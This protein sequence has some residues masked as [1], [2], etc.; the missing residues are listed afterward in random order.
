MLCFAFAIALLAGYTIGCAL[1]W[2]RELNGFPLLFTCYQPWDLWLPIVYLCLLLGR[3]SDGGQGAVI[4][5]PSHSHQ[6]P[7]IDLGCGLL[8]AD[9]LNRDALGPGA[10]RRLALDIQAIAQGVQDTRADLEVLRDGV[11]VLVDNRDDR[12]ADLRTRSIAEHDQ[13]FDE[14]RRN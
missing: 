6:A 12:I 8:G 13:N 9:P 5:A 11:S 14:N 7:A 3:L 10:A 4:A 2:D 1:L